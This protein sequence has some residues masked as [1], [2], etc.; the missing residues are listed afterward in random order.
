MEIGEVPGDLISPAKS[1]SQVAVGVRASWVGV[2]VHLHALTQ[3]VDGGLQVGQVTG[4]AVL[5]QPRQAG[6]HP[7]LGMILVLGGDRAP[8]RFE[9]PAGFIERGGA[10]PRLP[11]ALPAP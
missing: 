10:A 7:Y 5:P 6:V 2:W 9:M 4:P 8:R 3:L 1:A 11:H